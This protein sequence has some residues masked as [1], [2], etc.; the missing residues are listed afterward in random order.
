MLEHFQQI[1]ALIE[2]WRNVPPELLKGIPKE[3]CV[4]GEPEFLALRVAFDNLKADLRRM[5]TPA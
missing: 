4:V 3:Y 1:E 2:S 5:L